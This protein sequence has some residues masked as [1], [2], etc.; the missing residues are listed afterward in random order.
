MKTIAAVAVLGALW[1]LVGPLA[2]G[3]GR[4]L[5]VE[6]SRHVPAICLDSSAV[7]IGRVGDFRHTDDEIECRPT[8][9]I[10]GRGFEE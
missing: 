2:P 8:E 4:T 10:F 3:S 9:T 1:L 5:F 6:Q 7:M